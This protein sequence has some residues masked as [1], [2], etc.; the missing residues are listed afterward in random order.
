MTWVIFIVTSSTT[1]QKLYVGLPSVRRG[2]QAERVGNARRHV[3]FPALPRVAEGLSA[4][5]SGF[6]LGP[7]LL[8]RAHATIG[9][10]LSQ[11]ALGVGLVDLQPLRLAVA[12]GR[13][14]LVPVEPEPAQRL[15]D[16]GD[17]LL[18]GARAV[19]VLDPEDEHAAVA[20]REEPVEDPGVG[21][22]PVEVARR[23]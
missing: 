20:P 6:P 23:G 5:L 21:A 14:S 4:G 22:P 7:E 15:D 3:G 16:G 8:G 17:E 2:L 18:R 9:T 10:A 1:T 13:R 12:G 11:K 19:R